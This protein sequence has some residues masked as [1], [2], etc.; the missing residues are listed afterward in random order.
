MPGKV[1]A[2]TGA[3][4]GIGLATVEALAQNAHQLILLCRSLEKGEIV[5]EELQ[6]YSANKTIELLACDLSNFE[7]V[8]LAA[9]GIKEKHQHLDILINN[10]GFMGYPERQVSTNGVE[11]T[12]ATNHLGPFLLT[13]SLTDLLK[14]GKEG[15]IIN[16]NS[17]M[18]RYGYID[19]EDFQLKKKY[20]PMKAYARS[21][22]LNL[23]SNMVLA[24]KLKDDGITINNV[25]PGSVNT[26]IDRTYKKW[27]R[28]MFKIA[29]PFMR[30]PEKGAET[31]IYLC[32]ERSV[33]ETTGKLFKDKKI[34]PPSE[35][36]YDQSIRGEVWEWTF[37]SLGLPIF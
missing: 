3:T 28:T 14:S 12:I 26:S 16:L 13:L 9:S 1:I 27:F 23:V 20:K 32:E 37:K 31:S 25:D 2:I 24:E 34:I 4:S 5:R 36:V 22:F 15:R 6:Q 10:A 30:T 35:R 18:H 19:W 17:Y 29:G 33:G 8:R 11:V 7:S 21:K